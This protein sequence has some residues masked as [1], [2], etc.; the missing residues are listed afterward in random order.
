MDYLILIAAW[1]VWCAMH[2]ILISPSM[3]VFINKRLPGHGHWY[4][5]FY[6]SFSLVTLVPPVY[7]MTLID[8][9]EVFRWEGFMQIPRF[10][11]LLL[12]LILFKEGSKKY[13]LG[14]FL[15]IKQLQSGRSNILLNGDGLFAPTGVFGIVRHPWYTGSLLLVWSI[16]SVYTTAT[17][18]TAV[19]LS[20]YLVIGTLLEERKILAEY[21]DS[22]RF[23]Q[24]NV[25]MLFPWKWLVLR[26]NL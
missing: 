9:S 18:I 21:G 2:S 14:F 8:S 24:K 13:D 25:S 4:R 17:M 20:V 11:L 23:Y 16:F 22:Y 6:N 12:A 15:G 3:T 10:T 5:I 19:I 26:F 7:C 1:G